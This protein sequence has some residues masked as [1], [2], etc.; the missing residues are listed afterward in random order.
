MTH[1]SFRDALPAWLSERARKAFQLAN[2]E[3]HRLQH[4]AVGTEHLLLGLAKDGVSPAAWVLKLCG[5]NLA[6]LRRQFEQ[7]RPP[8]PDDEL[9]PG[10][11]P[12][13]ASLTSFIERI[14]AARASRGACV[15]PQQLLAGL[16]RA[17]AGDAA[18]ILRRRR[19][20]WWLL[21]WLLR[22]VA[23]PATAVD[24]PRGGCLNAA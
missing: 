2:Q 12:Y 20:S 24:R 3:A 4:R 11:L 14:E 23:D 17:P 6:W 15:T 19:V 13:A 1:V 10:S 22:R 9:L 16:I 18:G 5:F 8:G 21:Q 7:R